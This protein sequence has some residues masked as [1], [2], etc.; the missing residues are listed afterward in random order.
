MV[1][2]WEKLKPRAWC[3]LIGSGLSVHALPNVFLGG[4][5][6]MVSSNLKLSQDSFYSK[7]MLHLCMMTIVTTGL[8]FPRRDLLVQEK[9]VSRSS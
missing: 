3:M 7:Y 5:A 8:L 9:K 1:P 2:E 4:F 6:Q